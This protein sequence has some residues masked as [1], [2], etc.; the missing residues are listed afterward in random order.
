MNN[1]CDF[2]AAACS[3]LCNSVGH[4][5]YCYLFRIDDFWYPF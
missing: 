2:E 1:I 4:W 5:D 3:S